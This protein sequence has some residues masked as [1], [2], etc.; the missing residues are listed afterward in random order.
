MKRYSV[1][2]FNL[3]VFS[4]AVVF[5]CSNL[6]EYSKE[7]RPMCDRQIN[8]FSYWKLT[9]SY[10]CLE[11]CAQGVIVRSHSVHMDVTAQSWPCIL[12]LLPGQYSNLLLNHDPNSSLPHNHESTFYPV[13]RAKFKSFLASLGWVCQWIRIVVKLFAQKRH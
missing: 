2:Y 8:L 3:F 12:A 7:F 6:L 5:T 4:C 1:A 10:Y 11:T 9:E 13:T